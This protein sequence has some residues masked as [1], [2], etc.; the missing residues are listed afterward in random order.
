MCSLKKKIMPTYTQS[1]AVQANQEEFVSSLPFFE[2]KKMYTVSIQNVI[3]YFNSNFSKLPFAPMICS[4]S[5]K[6]CVWDTI[7]YFPLLKLL[8]FLS[9]SFFAQQ[10][11]YFSFTFLIVWK[12]IFYSKQWQFFKIYYYFLFLRLS[13]SYAHDPLF[14]PCGL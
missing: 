8:T 6:V 12:N 11:S 5:S 13:L 10:H 14:R 3:Y 9:F 2:E 4:G 7:S 1:I